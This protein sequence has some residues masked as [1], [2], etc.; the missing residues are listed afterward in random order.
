MDGMTIDTLSPQEDE[1]ALLALG[2]PSVY[3]AFFDPRRLGELS[4]WLDPGNWARDLPSG[5]SATWLEFLND[6]RAETPGRLIL[7]SPS[8][9]FRIDAL[10]ELF[11]NASYIWLVRDPVDTFLSNRKMWL[12]MFDR[13]ALWDA[14]AAGLDSFLGRAI[15]HAAECLQRAIATIPL[16]RLA[17]LRFDR[18]TNSPLDSL[19]RLNRRLS[20]GSWTEMQPSATNTA[21][22][23]ASRRPETYD[24]SEL[25]AA[26]IGALDRLD[27][28]QLEAVSSHG[29]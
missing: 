11:P 13:Y 14:D 15:E 12:A 29:L 10:P 18:L 23:R 8:H 19:E 24:R 7:K 16:Q 6:V 22:E 17:V 20:L 25:P 3:R 4:Q 2:V 1:F 21:S 27:S 28:A 26:I 9:S 5:W